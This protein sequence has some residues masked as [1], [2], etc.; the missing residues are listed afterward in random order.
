[1]GRI[2]A[3]AMIARLAVRHRDRARHHNSRERMVP[4]AVTPARSTASAGAFRRGQAHTAA[5]GTL[6]EHR[7]QGTR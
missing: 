7:I 3:E 5:A 6:F 2:A 4:G 1:M